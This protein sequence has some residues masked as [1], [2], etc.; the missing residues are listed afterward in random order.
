MAPALGWT[1]VA[2]GLASLAVTWLSLQHRVSQVR[3]DVLTAAAA[4]VATCGGLSI[5]TDVSAA[6][7]V[8]GPCL[9]A[10]GAIV[11]RRALFRGAGPFRT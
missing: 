2:V 9:A 1:L 10:V 3:A 4:T 7:W 8:V 11:H 6:S 5:L